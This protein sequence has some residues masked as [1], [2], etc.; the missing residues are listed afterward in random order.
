MRKTMNWNIVEGKWK[1]MA[2]SVKERWG[3]MTDNEIA[4]THGKRDQLEGLLQQKYGLTQ[5]A[6]T[7]QID[8]WA[9]KLKENI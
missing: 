4:E 7:E 9:N 5:Q 2:G 1:R 3:E 6:A 8:E